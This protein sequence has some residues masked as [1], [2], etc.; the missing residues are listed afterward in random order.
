MKKIAP[1]ILSADFS[2]LGEEI[3]AIEAGGAD[4]VHIDVMDGRFVPNI[5]TGRLFSRLGLLGEKESYQQV[6]SLFMNALAPDSALFNEYHAL[7]VEQCKRH[8]RKKPLCCG[9]PLRESCAF[10]A[11]SG[12]D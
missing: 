1:S 9:C 11:S 2:R 12:E 7:I 6:R 4:Y 8:C 5:T 3:K 10:P